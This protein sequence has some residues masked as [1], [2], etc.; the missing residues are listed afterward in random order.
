[1]S[2]SLRVCLGSKPRAKMRWTPD[3]SSAEDG[4]AAVLSWQEGWSKPYRAVKVGL[5]PSTKSAR[6]EQDVSTTMTPG[7]T[8]L[9]LLT[10]TML[11]T[12]SETRA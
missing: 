7:P 3:V 5:V 6:I 4:L 8:Q 9:Y 2:L 12:A 1:V 11:T 10:K